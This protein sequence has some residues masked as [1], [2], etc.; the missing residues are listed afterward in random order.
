MDRGFLGLGSLLGLV[1]FS[2][3]REVA[4]SGLGLPQG[5]FHQQ[6]WLRREDQEPPQ[7]SCPALPAL[8]SPAREKQILS[9]SSGPVIQRTP[10]GAPAT[11]ETSRAVSRGKT[12]TLFFPLSMIHAGLGRSILAG[13]TLC[14][15]AILYLTVVSL[16][17]C[18]CS[19]C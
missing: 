5:K 9:M 7:L 17:I 11:R 19:D 1:F 12:G 8:P 2:H 6:P 18:S 3:L 15:A 4:V 13:G 14:D 10:A 16:L